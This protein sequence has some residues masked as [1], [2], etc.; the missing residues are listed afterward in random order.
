MTTG[1]SYNVLDYGAKGDGVTDDILG[2]MRAVRA[3]DNAGGGEVYF[4][5]GFYNISRA[6]RLDAYDY[7]TESYVNSPMSKIAYRG[8]G[9][10]VTTIKPTSYNSI[11]TSF[12]EP[13][14]VND[15]AGGSPH[16]D[17]VT[18]GHDISIIGF[19]LDCD[20]DNVPD[21]G[22]A[23]YSTASFKYEVSKMGGTW[24]NGATTPTEATW[25]SDNY[26]YPI[27]AYKT[28]RLVIR[29]NLI[30]N[31][32]Y[33]GIELYN[34]HY[35]TIEN[36]VMHHCGDKANV[37]GFYTAVEF[38]LGS[39]NGWMTSNTVYNCGNGVMSNGDSYNYA[40]AP[41]S[42]IFIENNTFTDITDNGMYMFSWVQDW[43]IRGNVFERIGNSAIHAFEAKT[44]GA[45]T[46]PPTIADRH[47]DRFIISDNIIKGFNIDNADAT[48]IRFNGVSAIISNNIIFDEDTS[49]TAN[50]RAILVADS[51]ILATA[52]HSIN[53]TGNVINGRFPTDA[54]SGVIQLFCPGVVVS[55]NNINLIDGTVAYVP[56]KDSNT[57]T[58]IKDNVIAGTYASP[59]PYNV[60]GATDFVLDEGSH[61]TFVH[62]T[63]AAINIP[64]DA[65]TGWITVD[66]DGL[67]TIVKD[68]M[69]IYTNGTDVVE[70][71]YDGYYAVTFSAR[72]TNVGTLDNHIGVRILVERDSTVV[73]TDS[74][75]ALEGDNDTLSASGVIY[76]TDSSDIKF[77]IYCPDTAYDIS[78]L[79]MT[80]RY[81]G[82]Y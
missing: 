7:D 53:I 82:N 46:S 68:T 24:N 12:P 78:I 11:F 16:D 45:V 64:A 47:P 19:T 75:A 14:L 28:E 81:L 13:F 41:V 40:T 17:N 61:P 36:N 5:A 8:A 10:E 54:N 80:I 62:A 22:T 57:G 3:A 29:D 34:C 67:G 77:R 76:S 66:W 59:L 74:F 58:V 33:N 50:T 38:D 15:G 35:T 30:K 56:I 2:I 52:D 44:L 26:Q 49:T 23:T 27:Y 42:K 51:N 9:S 70:M 60:L 32:W 31:S 71:P 18:M 55:N 65:A 37:Y 48:A 20:Y 1:A 39:T 69:S 72:F 63:V 79:D 4:P 73:M 6:I 25:S 43:V 21:Y